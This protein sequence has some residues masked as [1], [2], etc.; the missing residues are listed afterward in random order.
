MRLYERRRSLS[1]DLSAPGLA[2]KGLIFI[3]VFTIIWCEIGLFNLSLKNCRWPGESALSFDRPSHVLIVSDVQV[4]NPAIAPS[5][6]FSFFAALRQL[7]FNLYLKRSWGV[8]MGLGPDHVVFLGD[9]TASGRRVVTDEEYQAYYQSFNDTFPLPNPNVTVHYL[10]GNNDIGLYMGSTNSHLA[11]DRYSKFF[12]PFNQVVS[13]QDHTL[14]L[15]DAPGFVEEDNVR[16]KDASHYEP[17]EDGPMDFVNSIEPGT[18]ANPTILFTHIPLSRPDTASCGPVRE[19]GAIR[20]GAGTGYQNMIGKKASS[21]LLEHIRPCVVFSG[22]DRDY[23]EYAHHVTSTDTVREVTV[24]SF[25]M[26]RDIRRPGFQLL[27]LVS[28]TSLA[29]SPSSATHFD[30]PCFLPDQYSTHCAVYL[31]LALISFLSLTLINL[32]R[33]RRQR[34]SILDHEAI[35]PLPLSGIPTAWSP[36]GPPRSPRANFFGTNSPRLRTPVPN[37]VSRTYAATPVRRASARTL[38]P[39]P[40][41]ARSPGLNPAEDDDYDELYPAQYAIRRD[42]MFQ[43]SNGHYEDEELLKPHS[44]LSTYFPAPKAKDVVPHKYD[45]S[46]LPWSWSFVLVGRRHRIT[47]PLLSLQLFSTCGAGVRVFFH[48]LIMGRRAGRDNLPRDVIMDCASVF[49]SAFG[50]WMAIAWWSLR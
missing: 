18:R 37:S 23:C 35:P 50:L 49:F 20:R 8:V 46:R 12:G 47:V 34:L 11:R 40:T 30:R 13:V 28:P 36:A 3:W 7:V 33:P 16:D 31:P 27:T 29:T 39:L 14:V 4:K 10:P 45:G 5:W 48:D 1:S 2:Q 42:E 15:L 19:R 26:A 44:T 38:S 43:L 17:V 22:D 24:K 6:L 25:S 41:S 32:R 9:M 21:F